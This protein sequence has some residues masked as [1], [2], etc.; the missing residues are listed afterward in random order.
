[1]WQQILVK[2]MSIETNRILVDFIIP[3]W[4]E[5]SSILLRSGKVEMPTL[6]Q[7]YYI[8]CK[9]LKC[10]HFICLIE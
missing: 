3:P 2:P 7:G 5:H 1:M 10:I 8:I 6:K 9:N 4:N